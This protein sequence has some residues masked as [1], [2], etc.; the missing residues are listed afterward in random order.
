[1]PP[2]TPRGSRLPKPTPTRQER[3]EPGVCKVARYHG[4]LVLELKPL[5]PL[6]YRGSSAAFK[7]DPPSP[8]FAP[9]WG[10]RAA[11]GDV[12]VV[13]ADG[14]AEPA[15]RV[16]LQCRLPALQKA[17]WAPDVDEVRGGRGRVWTVACR[18]QAA[19]SPA[20]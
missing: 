11:G 13:A 3:S 17:S 9:A 7:V 10:R 2:R 16:V 19:L 5:V 15:H 4:P 8:A 12:R 6:V 1:M 20:S 18:E 14:A